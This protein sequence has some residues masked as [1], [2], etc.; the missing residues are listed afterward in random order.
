L[1]KH[2]NIFFGFIFFI[3][4]HGQSANDRDIIWGLFHPVSA[5][6]IKKISKSLNVIY[7]LKEI[8]LELDSY[9]NGGKL[10]AFRHTFFMAA[11]AQKVKISKLRKLGIAHEK[12]NYRQFIKNQ[13]ENKEIPDS[14]GTVMD[15]FNNELGYKIGKAN[16]KLLLPD[17]KYIVLKEIQNGNALVMKRDKTGNYLDC[18]NNI[19]NTTLFFKKWFVPK[20]LVKSD[21]VY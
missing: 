11:F 2:L 17:L 9:E 1:L 15:L 14:M 3:N 5:I 19:I 20:C 8:K 7:N 13:T 16:K 12:G 10:D 18:E 6:K 21:Y 4:A